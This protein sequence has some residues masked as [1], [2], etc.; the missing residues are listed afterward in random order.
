LVFKKSESKKSDKEKIN[1]KE[2]I[3]EADNS[4]I[5]AVVLISSMTAVS[6]VLLQSSNYQTVQEVI[7]S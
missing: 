6:S 5:T 2:E 1:L 3:E 7:N 4:V